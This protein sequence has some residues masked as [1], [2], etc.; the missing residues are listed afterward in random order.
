M[1]TTTLSG[2]AIS[3]DFSVYQLVRRVAQQSA[4]LNHRKTMTLI[5]YEVENA[6]L[7]DGAH[8]II[9]SG[10]QRFSRFLPQLERYRQLA[11]QA[12]KVYV[13]GVPDVPVPA[14]PNIYFVPLQP[15]HQL[16]KEW[17]VVSYGADYYSALATEELTN[18]NHSDS[19]RIFQGVWTFDREMVSIIFEWLCREVN[20][21]SALMEEVTYRKQ[22]HIRLISNS[23]G[24]LM[25]ATMQERNSRMAA[26]VQGELKTVIKDGLYSA[27]QTLAP[28]QRPA[29]VQEQDM[30]ILFS[31]LRNFTTLAGR[32]PVRDLVEKIINPYMQIVSRAVHKH[33]GEVDK[34]LGDGVLAMFPERGADDC[35]IRRAV[36]AA[37][38]I[39]RELKA[40]PNQPPVGIGI[41]YG[42]VAISQ[43]GSF[44]THI[45]ETVIGDAVN[46]AQRLSTLGANDIYLSQKAAAYVKVPRL[47]MEPVVAELRGKPGVQSVYRVTH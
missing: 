7:I 16:A 45:E 32:L 26:I 38:D 36:A 14:I 33:G 29:P 15:S 44:H 34:F 10:F 3:P 35:G 47:P 11:H 19:L 1:S 30:A 41:D 20:D 17:F 13:F 23:I 18:V 37:Q 9:F 8:T 28:D 40:L 6:T 46:T 42:K 21:Q 39:M 43:L 31:D 4:L 27:L 24:R 22:T 5:S 12:Q 2:F 25:M